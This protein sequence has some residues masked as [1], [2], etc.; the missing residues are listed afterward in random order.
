MDKKY[1]WHYS[2][3]EFLTFAEN[4]VNDTIRTFNYK[5]YIT[6]HNEMR[7]LLGRILRSFNI[8]KRV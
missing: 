8:L 1:C 4:Y 6:P 7:E 3:D 2:D 5:N